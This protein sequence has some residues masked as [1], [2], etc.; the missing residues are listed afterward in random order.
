MG[1]EIFRS[2]TQHLPPNPIL[3]VF[4]LSHDQYDD[5]SQPPVDAAVNMREQSGTV[6]ATERGQL[7]QTFKASK[8]YTASGGQS[9]KRAFRPALSPDNN[10]KPKFRR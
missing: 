9:P 3:D 7:G 4:G 8:V 5:V 6:A 10:P 1:F 2:L